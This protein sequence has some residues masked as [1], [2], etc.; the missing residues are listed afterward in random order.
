MSRIVTAI[1]RIN[2]LV[3][4]AGLMLSLGW[5]SPVHAQ[6]PWMMGGGPPGMFGGGPP[7]MFGGP[8]GPP[9][10][11][12][13]QPQSIT[14]NPE[15]DRRVS[16]YEGLIRQ[17]DTNHDGTISPEELSQ[18][19][20][21]SF[22]SS[23]LTERFGVDVSRGFRIDEIRQ[24]VIDYYKQRYEGQQSQQGSSTPNSGSTPTNQPQSQQVTV[25]R[26]GPDV[27]VPGFGPPSTSTTSPA[28][29]VPGF[30]LPTSATATSA[31][32]Q[33]T[34]GTA[35][36]PSSGQSGSESV[37]GLPPPPPLDERIRRYAESLMRQYDENHNGK[38]EKDEWSKMRGSDWAKADQNGDGELTL[39]EIGRHLAGESGANSSQSGQPTATQVSNRTGKRFIQRL[40]WE[41]LPPDLPSWFKDRDKDKDGQVLMSEFTDKWTPDKLREFQKYDLNGDG[42]ITPQ[43]CVKAK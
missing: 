35:A 13:T 23:R 16:F 41:R 3:L 9:G 19:R 31:T 18:S 38:L 37:L 2:L 36:S 42:V 24:K 28:P 15:I 17:L 1:G 22:L 34:G 27:P 40:P 33:N 5:G 30:G 29:T 21:G 32:A 26:I 14:G 20:M 7:G 11:P 6:P 39:E 4:L 8:G 10:M 25:L 12:G 43:E